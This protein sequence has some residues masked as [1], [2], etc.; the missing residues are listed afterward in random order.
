M[1]FALNQGI[2]IH[3]RASGAGEPLLLIMGLGYSSEMWHHV[4]AGLAEHF[5]VI[6]FDNRGIGKSESA[7][8]PHLIPD[9]AN[10]AAAVLDAAGVDC[11]FVLGMSMGG[12]I[13]QELALSH[14]QRV[15]ALVLG[16]TACGGA[17]VTSADQKVLDVLMERANMPPE[18]GIRAMIPYIYDS[19]TPKDRIE[20]DMAVR[21]ANYPDAETYLGQIEG[22]RLWNSCD[23]LQQLSVPTLILHGENDQLIPLANGRL[24][25]KHIE[26][27]ELQVLDEASHI[28]TTDQPNRTVRWVTD[29]LNKQ[30]PTARKTSCKSA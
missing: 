8:G 24:L 3:W 10:D 13:A 5:R 1:P 26:G 16:C 29:F 12:Y 14:P 4:E 6:V 9:M 7:P 23:R 20:A 2:R 28:F 30:D 18:Q 15:Q 11:A 17:H 27:S 21:L 25:A 22:V 19:G